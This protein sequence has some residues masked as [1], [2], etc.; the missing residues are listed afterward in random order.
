MQP[1]SLVTATDMRSVYASFL[2]ISLDSSGLDARSAKTRCYKFMRAVLL[3]GVSFWGIFSASAGSCVFPTVWYY[4]KTATAGKFGVTQFQNPPVGKP[5]KI[6]RRMVVNYDYSNLNSYSATCPS[7]S[8]PNSCGYIWNPGQRTFREDVTTGIHYTLT[9]DEYTG[10]GAFTGVSGTHTVTEKDWDNRLYKYNVGI[11]G[12]Q[13]NWYRYYSHTDSSGTATLLPSMSWTGTKTDSSVVERDCWYYLGETC[14]NNPI[15]GRTTVSTG[16]TSS[17]AG[18]DPLSLSGVITSPTSMS[19]AD[20]GGVNYDCNGLSTQAYST[21]GSIQLST[22]FTTSRMI[23]IAIERTAATQTEII[24]GLVEPVGMAYT[25]MPEDET[26]VEV[27]KMWFE[28]DFQSESLVTYNVSWTQVTAWLNGGVSRDKKSVQVIGNGAVAAT[29]IFAVDPPRQNGIIYITDVVACPVGSEPSCERPIASSFGGGCCG[30][31]TSASGPL[32]DGASLSIPL[33]TTAYDQSAGSIALRVAVPRESSVGVGALQV[34]NPAS[35]TEVI[36][37]ASGRVAQ[38]KS[39]QYLAHVREISANKFAVHL[40]PSAQIGAKVSGKYPTNGATETVV[41][42]ADA[43]LA[44][45]DDF[46]RVTFGEYTG[47]PTG[48]TSQFD[49]DFTLNQWT[50]TQPGGIGRLRQSA[51]WDDATQILTEKREALDPA[52]SAVLKSETSVYR[53]VGAINGSNSRVEL[54]ES[55]QGFGSE[56]R[57][58]TYSYDIYSGRRT[59]EMDWAGKWKKYAW[60]G[61]RITD[62]F[63]GFGSYT[64]DDFLSDSVNCRRTSYLYDTEDSVND[65]GSMWPDMARSETESVMG[66]AVRQTKRVVHR[67]VSPVIVDWVKEY[68]MPYED[69]PLTDPTTLVTT[70]SFYTSGAW[71]GRVKSILLPD[72][73]MVFYGYVSSGGNLTTTVDRGQPNAGKTAIVAGSRS[74]TVVNQDGRLISSTTSD[75][76]SSLVTDQKVYSNF[77]TRGRPQTVTYLD[78]TTELYSYSCCTLDSFTGRDGT[79]TSYG[80]DSLKRRISETTAGIIQWSDYDAA[81]NVWRTRRQGTDGSV[82]TLSQNHYNSA[83]E[84]DL[85]IDQRGATTTFTDTLVG[86]VRTRTTTEAV[87]LPEELTRVETYSPNGELLETSGTGERPVRY[88]FGILADGALQVPY[89]LTINLTAAGTTTGTN[90]WSASLTDFF[91]RNYKTIYSDST[92]ATLADNATERSFYDNQGRLYKSIDPDGVTTLYSRPNFTDSVTAVDMNLNG[93]IDYAGTDRITKTVNEVAAAYGTTIRR[94]TTYDYTLMNNA[95]AVVTDVSESSA[96]GLRTWQTTVGVANPSTTVTAYPGGGYRNVTTTAPDGSYTLNSFLNGRLQSSTQKLGTGTQIGRTTYTYDVHGRQWKVTDARNGTTIFTYDSADQVTTVTTPAPGN[97]QSAQTTVTAYDNLGRVK[98][99]TRPDGT[100]ASSE[101]YPMGLLKRSW[102]SQVYPVEYSYDAQGRMKTLKTYR[103]FSGNWNSPGTADTTTWNYHAYRGWLSNKRYADSTGPDYFYFPSGRMQKRQWARGSPRVESVWTYNSAGDV[104]TLTYNNDSSL[105]PDLA[106]GYDR[107]GC[108]TTVSSVGAGG[109]WTVTRTF[110]LQHNPLTEIY[111]GTHPLAGRTITLTYDSLLRRSTFALDSSPAALSYL[112]GYDGASHLT[113]VSDGAY[114]A[115][116]AYLANSPLIGT[117]TLKQGTSARLVTTRSYDFL[118]R[119]MGV[120]AQPQVSGSLP[121]GIAYQYNNLNQRT[122]QLLGDG[123]A[124]VYDYDSVGQVTSG[125]LYF[126][127]GNPVPGQQFEYAFDTIGNRSSAKH[128]GDA[129]GANLRSDTYTV[130]NLNQYGS[131]SAG[132]SR[133]ADILGLAAAGSSVTVNGA[134]ASR[135]GEYFR[136]E[137]AVSG[138]APVW[139]NVDVTT[140][141]G[142]SSTAKKLY[143]PPTPEN[144][145][146][147][148]DGNLTGDGRWTYIWDAENRLVQMDTVAAAYNA[149]V[150]RQRLQYDYDDQGRRIRRRVSNWNGSAYVVASDVRL[151]LDGWNVVAELN[152]LASNALLRSYLWGCDLSG[153]LDGAGGVGGLV[154]MMPT[155]GNA[156]FAAYDGNGSIIGLVD[157]ATATTTANY[158]YSPFGETIRMTGTQAAANP[159]RFST[160]FTEADSGLLYYG[161]R[162]YQPATG[163]WSSRD[164]LEEGGGIQLYA[165]V[166]NDPISTVDNL[167]LWGVANHHEVIQNFVDARTGTVG[168]PIKWDCFA[169]NAAREMKRGNDFVDG[170]AGSFLYT[171]Y[172]GTLFHAN[173]VEYSYQHA[174]TAPGQGVF[175]A[176]VQTQLFV[177]NRLKVAMRQSDRARNIYATDPLGSFDLIKDAFELL[178]EAQHPIADSTSPAHAGY[179]TWNGTGPKAIPSAL[180]HHNRETSKIF[181]AGYAA[182]AVSTVDSVF[183]EAFDYLARQPGP[184]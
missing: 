21:T 29:P 88:A 54:L 103:A 75:I 120:T 23:D 177:M 22:E 130:N 161:Y 126:G 77:D 114:S 71:A 117:V 119:L 142:G 36:V 86:G 131:R 165:F 112:Y 158:D 164:P 79:V 96:D 125:K 94:R 55:R 64:Y 2:V 106:Y 63:E 180:K 15:P 149:G 116:Y 13:P 151:A 14:S 78:A 34:N 91:G 43:P 118:N 127:D 132:G 80:Y 20:P 174:M 170:T 6:Y 128:G 38:V 159:F 82:I 183:G 10:A 19:L 166:R 44:G 111:G 57:I 136:Q 143:V 139:Q 32:L 11:C 154:F 4:T 84:L 26:S 30:G 45:Q 70:T 16:G 27:Q 73:T 51:T 173:R 8:N 147:D 9:Y 98:Q 102:G 101:Y 162:Y 175:E 163:R 90:E 108:Q 178:G 107:H 179:Q 157:G 171:V 172:D 52:T 110:D 28:I 65:D 99:V 167:G 100:V 150:P 89:R 115:T 58:T 40:F 81:G 137:L 122:R 105:T 46:S 152:G 35:D 85:S 49:Y 169:V 31:S 50:L 83:G 53:V 93:I 104:A 39:R 168:K 156:Q 47:G 155:G 33:G 5:P 124:W 95:T 92:P 24:L 61:N 129:G 144:F 97:G 140:S 66:V 37:D 69:A 74:V 138:S 184:Y 176:Y 18:P 72:Q 60:S 3:L 62:R 153:T 68:Q 160:K 12:G 67:L 133:Y 48:K 41:W 76:A 109:T 123:S 141:G 42:L 121:L 135:R 7:G 146:Y 17:F 87:G 148:T 181:A 25:L 56:E 182:L 134:T 1:F 145:A 113:S 59:L